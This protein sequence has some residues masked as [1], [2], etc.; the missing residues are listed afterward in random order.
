MADRQ[1]DVAIVGGGGAGTAAALDLARAGARTAVFEAD[2]L[3]AGASTRNGGLVATALHL[4]AGLARRLDPGRRRALEEEAAAA[5][6]RLAT[7]VEH[8][9]IA[10][11]L[12]RSGRFIGARGEQ[13][14]RALAEEAA[15]LA[16]AGRPVRMVDA[17][18]QRTVIGSDAFAG[19]MVVEDAAV[20]HPA[21][22]HRGLRRA[23]RAAGAALVARTRVTGLDRETRGTVVSFAAPDGPGEARAREVIVATGGEPAAFSPW[24]RRRVVPVASWLIATEPLDATVARELSP[25]GL[26]FG[27]TARLP[28]YFRLTPDGRRLLFGGRVSFRGAP[29]PEA[30]LRLRR[31]MLAV[32]PQL[33]DVRIAHAWS[34]RLSFTRDRLPHLAWHDGVLYAAGCQGSGVATAT[35]LGH[36]AARAILDGTTGAFAAEPW[37]PIPLYDGSPWF[38]PAIGAWC[39]LRDALAR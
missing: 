2:A 34:G 25:A 30:A 31:R 14:R 38:V 1:F 20:V 24:L 39:R 5:R 27:D 4:P 32:F 22:L 9:A 6:A 8:E 10:D 17:A 33:R 13:A 11:T 26:S 15:E 16:A 19:G 21:R 29:V 28:A 3:G 18:E 36:R 37:R 23:A 12:A 35:W 7:L